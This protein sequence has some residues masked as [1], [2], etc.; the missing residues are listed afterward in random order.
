MAR[1]ITT[2]MANA[3][4]AAHV[5]LV[6]LVEVD[7]PDGVL[8]V[9]TSGVTL[10][11]DGHDWIGAGSL[12]AIQPVEESTT[13]QAAALAVQFS[14]IDPAFVS[15]IM[16]D[17]YQGRSATIWIA[18]LTASGEIVEDPV[19]MFSGYVDEPTVELGGS[20][21]VTLTL[22]NEWARWERA[23]DLMYT[24]AEQQAEYPGDTG[25]RYV[26][27][28]EN[29]ELSWGQYKGPA[30]PKVNV[31]KGVKQ[32]LLHPYIPAVNFVRNVFRKVF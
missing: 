13:P 30:A 3:L 26:E 16:V 22:E 17:H 11:W 27:E 23:P 29:L 18:A 2:A 8:R 10:T 1:T 25:F 31:P 19:V 7:L 6:A 14:G 32:Y 15:Q 28:L 20:A 9:N 5:D 12:T 21:T 4:A 24:D